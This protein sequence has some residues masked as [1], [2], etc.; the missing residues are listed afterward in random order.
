MR[1]DPDVRVGDFVAADLAP[2]GFRTKSFL[3]CLGDFGDDG[4]IRIGIWYV[5]YPAVVLFGD[6]LHVA[7]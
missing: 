6:H 3:L 4:E 1:E 5:P 2:N 7:G